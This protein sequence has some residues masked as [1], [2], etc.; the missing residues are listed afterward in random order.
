MIQTIR[1]S[2]DVVKRHMTRSSSPLKRIW[3]IQVKWMSGE[4]YSNRVRGFS[5]RVADTLNGDAAVID[6]RPG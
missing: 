2:A 5:Q 6:E 3:E 1:L 4:G